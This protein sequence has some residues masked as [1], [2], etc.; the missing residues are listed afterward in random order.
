MSSPIHADV[1]DAPA[2]DIRAPPR[3]RHSAGPRSEVRFR[4]KADVVWLAGQPLERSPIN[5]LV[6]RSDYK[7]REKC[8]RRAMKLNVLQR[9]GLVATFL[10]S[11]SALIYWVPKM[12]RC[13]DAE[14]WNC[15]F[16]VSGASDSGLFWV[17]PHALGFARLG[18]TGNILFAVVGFPIL[19]WLAVYA[20]IFAGRWILA[21]QEDPR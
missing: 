5:R 18:V 17:I 15:S 4:P 8:Y 16:I 10:W 6:K 21:G 1:G 19:I 11:A 3:R 9:A 20:A 12:Q 13:T 14:P 7:P 2:A